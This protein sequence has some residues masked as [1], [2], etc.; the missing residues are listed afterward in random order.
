[1]A[2]NVFESLV[3]MNA[4]LLSTN[5]TTTKLTNQ[6][7]YQI[8]AV[9]PATLPSSWPEIRHRNLSHARHTF[10][11]ISDAALDCSKAARRDPRHSPAISEHRMRFPKVL[12]T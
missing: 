2:F 5:Q 9:T 12:L 1:M 8:V 6:N 4:L 10:F 3:R 11:F 7:A